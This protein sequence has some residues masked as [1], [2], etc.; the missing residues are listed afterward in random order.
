MVLRLVKQL[1]IIVPDLPIS[2]VG[3]AGND[4][5]P[6]RLSSPLQE[7]FP[8]FVDAVGNIKI[9]RMLKQIFLA[10]VIPV[11]GKPHLQADHRIPVYF[12]V[13]IPPVSE[14]RVHADV[15]PADVEAAHVTHFPVDHH[16]FPV[17]A[18]IDAE[19]DSAQGCGEKRPHLHACLLQHAPFL[20]RHKPAA[21]AVVEDP[22]LHSLFHLLQK[23]GDQRV[24]QLV[25]FYDVVLDMDEML[26]LGHL[27]AK[28]LKLLFSIRKY[29]HMV[30]QRQ[31]R[32]GS[33]QI[34]DHHILV[35]PLHR[36]FQHHLMALEVIF[37]AP[38]GD[39]QLVLHLLDPEHLALVQILAQKQIE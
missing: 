19:V 3:P 5:D 35:I 11:L 32:T 4:L 20:L 24:K 12:Q 37:L 31:H 1:Q 13:G 25:V 22:H 30:V 36:L 6:Q 16:D 17:V 18:V 28:V 23:N 7:L 10:G 39:V 8:L 38:G 33:L 34:I 2:G 26:R 9:L 29:G 27:P 21:H 15:L 14:L